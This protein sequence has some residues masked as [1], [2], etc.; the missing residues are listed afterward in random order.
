M[1]LYRVGSPFA[2]WYCLAS[3]M[4]VST[5]SEPEETKKVESRSPGAISAILA[6]S[7]RDL[8]CWKLQFG[9]NPSSFIW[10]AATS[11][12]SVL[13]CPTCVVKS[14]ARPSM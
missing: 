2:L 14:P 4:T 7:S 11:P 8:G 10:A 3:F 6:A 1:I 12:N 13:P 9:K 5:A